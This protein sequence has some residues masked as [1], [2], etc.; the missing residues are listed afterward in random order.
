RHFARGEVVFERNTPGSSLF[1]I[2]EGSVVVEVNKDDP[3][4]TVPIEQGSIFGEVGL[5]PGRRRGS[6]VRAA[7]DLVV[8]ELSRTAALKLMA[9]APS[10]AR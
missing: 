6:T 2:A 3:S 5:I 7:E 9:T 8:V 4:I 10:A 1:A